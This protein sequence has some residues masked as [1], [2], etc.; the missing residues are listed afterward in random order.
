MTRNTATAALIP[1]EIEGFLAP[2]AFL[3]AQPALPNG[4]AELREFRTFFQNALLARLTALGISAEDLQI[5]DLTIWD[6]T[7]INSTTTFAWM[8]QDALIEDRLVKEQALL[9]NP[10]TAHSATLFQNE[11]KSGLF[12]TLALLDGAGS[13]D[14]VFG[15]WALAAMVP[16]MIS[17]RAR[18]S[19][20][21][22]RPDILGQ[23][24]GA[25]I[26]EKDFRIGVEW[27]PTFGLTDT[28]AMRLAED[29]VGVTR[30]RTK[31]LW[32]SLSIRAL[33]K[34]HKPA[35]GGLS[36][37]DGTKVDVLDFIA[38]SIALSLKAARPV[39]VIRTAAAPSAPLRRAILAMAKGPEAPKR[40]KPSRKIET[41]LKR[42]HQN[43]PMR[44][45][46]IIQPRSRNLET[47]SDEELLEQRRVLSLEPL[48]ILYGVTGPTIARRIEEAKARLERAAGTSAQA[49]ETTPQ[50]ADV[51]GTVGPISLL[52]A[53]RARR[54]QTSSDQEI[55]DLAKSM[56][57][58]ELFDH[59]GLSQDAVNATIDAAVARQRAAGVLPQLRGAQASDQD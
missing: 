49:G 35:D 34:V 51:D 22:C 42:R 10:Y 9:Q 55:I 40:R 33:P 58:K 39:R 4:A 38:L 26:F 12:S 30:D 16:L 14:E 48:S 41:S 7:A 18:V 45:R 1:A 52:K 20:V 37:A 24:T 5:R 32:P 54:F 29:M 57:R 59:L 46:G 6:P 11:T 43:L 15:A 21:E 47:T 8:P 50:A 23:D 53:R 19:H 56:P 31:K 2:A 27:R 36:G 25:A 17:S 13:M 44:W 28:E 3:P